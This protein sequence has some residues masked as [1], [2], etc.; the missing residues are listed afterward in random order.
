[1]TFFRSS[2]FWDRQPFNKVVKSAG[3]C[4]FVVCGAWVIMGPVDD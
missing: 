2:H 3:D 4:V 1:M